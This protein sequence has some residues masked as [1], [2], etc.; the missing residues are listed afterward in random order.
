MDVTV[1]VNSRKAGG[2]LVIAQLDDLQLSGLLVLMLGLNG[3][4]C[5]F[6]TETKLPA[7]HL[8]TADRYD[9]QCL[10][11]RTDPLLTREHQ[12]LA[13]R[14][15]CGAVI[16]LGHPGDEVEIGLVELIDTRD[17]DRH[18]THRFPAIA[19]S[20]VADDLLQGHVLPTT[21]SCC[22]TAAA[23][24]TGF[25]AYHQGVGR[26]RRLDI[27]HGVEAKSSEAMPHVSMIFPAPRMSPATLSVPLTV[28]LP[29]R[30]IVPA[31]A[32]IA[33]EATTG[34]TRSKRTG[35]RSGTGN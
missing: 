35:S 27:V 33:L 7:R 17:F 34:P 22:P 13:I 3:F 5:G 23:H 11:A 8:I 20:D 24:V 14:D 19:R 32:V 30:V 16:L 1:G 10:A 4:L 28:T 21:G 12:Q 18:G 26:T 31:L 15:L 2:G 9:A 6:V 25:A 29:S